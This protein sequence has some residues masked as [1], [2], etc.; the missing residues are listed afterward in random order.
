MVTEDNLSSLHGESLTVIGRLVN[1]SN[2]SLFC[3]VGD[4][5]AIYKPIA[6]ERPLWDFQSGDLASREVA[7]FLVSEALKLHCVPP[8]IMREGPYGKGSVQL[9]IEDCEYLGDKYRE[10]LEG[11]RQIALL[12]AVINN[13]DRKVGHLLFKEGLIF[14]CDHGLTFHEEYKLRTVLWQFA[15]QGLTNIEISQLE[16]F[17]IDL[18][19][20]ISESEEDALKVRIANLLQEKRFPMPPTNWP[21]IPWPPF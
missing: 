8:T 20:L 1:A 13:T 6:G 10:P 12:D 7:A 4:F 15:G 21:A 2:A 11:L 19:D 5:K 14:G 16:E 17:E 18:K 3:Q 9:W